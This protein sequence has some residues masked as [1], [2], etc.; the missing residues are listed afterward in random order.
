MISYSQL[1][2]IK[3]LHLFFSYAC[4]PQIHLTISITQKYCLKDSFSGNSQE[5]VYSTVWGW[6]AA[7]KW[8]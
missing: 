3:I 2:K 1:E 7:R 4:V 5:L 8:R 6:H